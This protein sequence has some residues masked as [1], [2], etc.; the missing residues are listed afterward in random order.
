MPDQ[1]CSENGNYSYWTPVTN[2]EYDGTDEAEWR[3]KTQ[4]DRVAH[5]V[6]EE[7]REDDDQR[8]GPR[9]N[10]VQ[11]IVVGRV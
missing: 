9:I 5:F 1:A 3:E 7:S 6:D 11:Q 8:V 2:R 4:T 10:R